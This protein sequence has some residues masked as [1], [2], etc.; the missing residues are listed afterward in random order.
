MNDPNGMVFVDGVYHLFYQYYPESNV[1]GPMHWGHA[2]S[3]DLVHWDHKPVALYPDKHGYI[4]SGSAVYD[5]KNTSGLGSQSNPPLVAI[6]TYHDPVGHDAG[7]NDFQTQGIAFS[8]DK[9]ESWEKYE[10]NPVLLNPGIRDFRDPK[11]TWHDESQKWIMVLAVQ[12]HVSFY[13][14]PNLIDWTFESDFGKDAGA[15]GG[16]WECPEWVE[17]SAPDGSSKDLL[18]VSLN[19]GGPNQGSGT[20][21]FL[22]KFDGSVFH[23]DNTETRWIDFGPDNYA[24]VTWANTGERKIFIGW[25][26]NWLYATLVPTEVW[27]SAMTIPRELSL[28]EVHNKLTL[29]SNP[30]PELKVLRLDSIELTPGVISGTNT[31]ELKDGFSASM[32]ELNLSFKFSNGSQFGIASEFGI[33]ISN[34]DN[35]F[36]E[37][38]IKTADEL[39]YIDRR[40]SGKTGFKE[41]F[42]GLH[43]APLNLNTSEEIELQIF[44]DKS[45][46]EVFYNDGEVVMTEI[47][48]PNED[49]NQIT[50]ISENGSI[51]LKSG[52]IYSLNSI[53]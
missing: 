48:F 3:K 38:G 42:A 29:V 37:I 10:G 49:L 39:M 21:Y 46:I 11:V 30:V 52:K 27:R 26:S 19:P 41:E 33:H 12:D 23:P 22:G 8:L 20:Q 45:S 25:M 32:Y 51:K 17:M 16:V 35:E 36:I 9:G 34:S 44:I 6:Y 2:V 14:S 13:S 47:F 53:W 1:W 31:I 40:Y 24:G 5:E 15:H 18:I 50:L 7:R 28:R 4:F 43:T